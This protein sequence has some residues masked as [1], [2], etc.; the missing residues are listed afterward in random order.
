MQT[1]RKQMIELLDKREVSAREISQSL[2][3]REKEVYGHLSHISRSVNAQRKKRQCS[4]KKTDYHTCQVFGM[5]ICFCKTKA[6][7][8]PESLSALQKRTHPESGVSN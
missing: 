4:E 1:I 6:V 2:S 3:M 5:R 8:P 7:H